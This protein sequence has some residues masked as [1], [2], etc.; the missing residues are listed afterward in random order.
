MSRGPI[1]SC[2]QQLN[3]YQFPTLLSIAYY[4]CLTFHW[5]QQGIHVRGFIMQLSSIELLYVR[6]QPLHKV[7]VTK[8]KS[9]EGYPFGACHA[10]RR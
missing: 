3:F 8:Q 5:D 1:A 4:R 7:N 2:F 9:R 6:A 10:Q